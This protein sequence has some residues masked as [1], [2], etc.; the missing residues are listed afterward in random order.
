MDD[1]PAFGQQLVALFADVLIR[2]ANELA[3]TAGELNLV[4]GHQRVK[5]GAIRL[6]ALEIGADG[7]DQRGKKF[8]IF[9][10]YGKSGR[11]PG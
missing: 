3:V 4:A 7:L 9:V 6:W 5:N 10:R 1:D 2:V 8:F 11:R